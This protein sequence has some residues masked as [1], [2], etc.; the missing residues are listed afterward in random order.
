MAVDPAI[1]R[2]QAA[3][4]PV[5][6]RAPVLRDRILFALAQAVADRRLIWE[7]ERRAASLDLD[8]LRRAKA[9]FDEA[10]ISSEP[11]TPLDSSMDWTGAPNAGPDFVETVLQQWDAIMARL[12]QSSG[13]SSMRYGRHLSHCMLRSDEEWV[14]AGRPDP[15]PCTCGLENRERDQ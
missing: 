9:A 13:D 11:A 4:A 12:E 3:D 5:L 8:L 14:S 15:C 2:Q 10:M 1:V 7:Q 6:R